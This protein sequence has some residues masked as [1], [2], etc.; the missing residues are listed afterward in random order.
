M[1]FRGPQLRNN[2]RVTIA[3]ATI[4]WGGAQLTT[5]RIVLAALIDFAI[6]AYI[7]WCLRLTGR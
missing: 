1:G 5:L 4:Y 7:I 3:V 2:G 6:V